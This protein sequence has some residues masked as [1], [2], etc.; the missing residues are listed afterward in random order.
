MHEVN[1]L[2]HEW[3]S[4]LA[5]LKDR[6]S[7]QLG[8]KLKMAI[9]VGMLPVDLQNLILGSPDQTIGG[10]RYPYYDK[11]PNEKA[12][13]GNKEAPLKPNDNQ[14]I[15]KQAIYQKYSV[16]AHSTKN[17]IHAN[18]TSLRRLYG[19]FENITGL[20]IESPITFN[21]HKKAFEMMQ[22]FKRLEI[23]RPSEHLSIKSSP[24]SPT[25]VIG[26]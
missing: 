23:P 8:D 2:I 3:E 4:N 17:N 18:G 6:Y 5:I 16:G 10:F 15:E 22:R 19:V 14:S 21:A 25:L 24:T 20:P 7:E 13:K 11:P 1:K 26:L 9:L 12:W